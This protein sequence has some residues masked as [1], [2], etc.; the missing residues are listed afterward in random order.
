VRAAL[1]IL[2]LLVSVTVS[3]PSES[4]AVA[5]KYLYSLSAFTGVIR[6]NWSRVVVDRERNEVYAL[7]Q[8]D[9]RIF[10]EA[11]MEVYRFGDDLDLGQISDVAVDDRGDVLLLTYKDSRVGIVRCDYRGRPQ[12][13][14]RLQGLPPGFADF[15]PNRLV[16]EGGRLYLAST[17]TLRVVVANT[18]GTVVAAHDL[19]RLLDLEEE[20]RSTTD[21]GGFSVDRD[22]NILVT[23]PV[24]FRAF[25]VSPQGAVT[26]FGR[27][28]SGPGRFNIV[29]GIVR[30]SKGNVL[31]VDRLK[32]AVLVFD[33]KLQFVSQFATRGYRP[34]QLISPDALAID[35]HD[36]VYVTQAARRGISVFAVTHR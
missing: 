31:V 33:R 32:G 34:G 19:V 36:R 5:G 22:G 24:L 21:L 7:Y 14:I 12:E 17:V 8:G 35:A 30:D 28:G 11:G 2:A 15:G 20:D 10:N 23:I 25:V 29:G 26:A 9:V 4:Q 18:D 3:S 27:A 13:E 1:G 6:Q 16:F